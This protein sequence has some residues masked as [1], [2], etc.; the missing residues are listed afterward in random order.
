[1]AFVVE[2]DEAFDPVDVGFF[3]A[4]GIALEMYGVA[5]ATQETFWT[6]FHCSPPENRFALQRFLYYTVHEQDGNLLYRLNPEM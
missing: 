3:G 1:M 4:D 2:E 6:V 5:N